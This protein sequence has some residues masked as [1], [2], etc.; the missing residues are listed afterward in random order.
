MKQPLEIGNFRNKYKSPHYPQHYSCGGK[1]LEFF[2][3]SYVSRAGW[4]S[5]Q[6]FLCVYNQ[7]DE[8]EFCRDVGSLD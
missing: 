5:G 1:S 7:K 2:C 4:A 8:A 6:D 3:Y